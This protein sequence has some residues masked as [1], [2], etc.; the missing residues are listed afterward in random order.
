M[1]ISDW[2]SDVCS[3]DLLIPGLRFAPYLYGWRIR[4]RI[5]KHYGE[6]MA[7]ER[8]VLEPMSDEQRAALV[9]QL[10]KIERAVVGMKTPGA[11]AD[12]AYILR[13]HIKFVRE[14]L[15]ASGAQTDDDVAVM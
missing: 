4:R 15:T 12:Q 11:F 3:S 14:G 9:E 8:A 6:L 5:Y 13:R 10:D 1:R 2:S 7:L